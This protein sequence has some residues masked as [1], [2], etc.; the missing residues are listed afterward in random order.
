MRFPVLLLASAVVCA[1]APAW[2][3]APADAPV[4][5]ANGTSSAPSTQQ[6][7]DAF[8]APPPD[9]QAADDLDTVLEEGPRRV[10]GTVELSVG[11]GGY[12]SGRVDAVVPIGER[13]SLALS[14]G[15]TRSDGG[16]VQGYEA[17]ERGPLTL[18]G[19]PGD[20]PAMTVD[21][22]AGVRTAAGYRQGSLID[23]ARGADRCPLR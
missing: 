13:S 23:R 7:I 22:G 18:G 11:T 4:A 2:S 16:Y 10:H 15:Q 12:R 20:E 5:T 19:W 9:R 14:Y 1:A 17:L 21:C 3:Q 8:L 6:Q